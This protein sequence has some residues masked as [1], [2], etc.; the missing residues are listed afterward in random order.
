MKLPSEYDIIIFTLSMY[1][2][3]Y[4]TLI[5]NNYNNFTKTMDGR[6]YRDRRAVFSDRII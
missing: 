3:H 5:N 4:R 1:R 6:E 2:L